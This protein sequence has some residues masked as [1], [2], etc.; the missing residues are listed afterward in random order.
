VGEQSI[1][2]N[3]LGQVRAQYGLRWC[4]TPVVRALLDANPEQAL[5]ALRPP[6]LFASFLGNLMR[7][8]IELMRAMGHRYAKQALQLRRFDRFLQS[9]PE[10]EGNTLAVLLRHWADSRP[11]AEH[12]LTCQEVG[13]IV[14]KA[15][16]RMDPD[17]PV[18]SADPRILH[19]VKLGRRQPTI[20]TPP[21]VRQLLDTACQ[22]PSPH[23]PLRPSA[24]CAMIV[25]AYCAGLRIGEIVRLDLA[26]IHLETAE[27]CIRDTKFFKSRLLPLSDS[28]M[29]ALRQYI[30]LRRLAGAPQ[31]PS[32]PLFWHDW[33]EGQGK[34]YNVVAAGQLLTKVMRRAGLKPSQGKVGPR[35]HDLRHSF[36]VNRMLEWY[37]AGVNPQERLPYLATYLGHKDINSTLAY[38]TITPELLQQAAE[39][40]RSLAAHCLGGREGVRP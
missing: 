15:W 30:E 37:R 28:A 16:R 4:T 7:D 18:P 34:R 40:F 35:V 12:T 11:T 32:S 19:E 13:L 24:L 39:R 25:L 33:H 3:P 36:V 29:T 26:D 5:E 8:H 1:S 17:I 2:I 31:E 27:I 6:P 21:Q 14:A 10:L 9:R 20:L 22:Y 38:L 23:V